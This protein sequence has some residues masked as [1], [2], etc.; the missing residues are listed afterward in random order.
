[1][2]TRGFHEADL[3]AVIDDSADAIISISSGGSILGFNPAAERLFHRDAHSTIGQ[4]VN[5]LMPEPHRSGHDAYMKRYL[6]TGVKR[7]LGIGRRVECIRPDGKCFPAYLSVSEVRTDG[8]IT[9]TGI[10]RDLTEQQAIEDELR[11]T[12]E[13]QLLTVEFAPIGIA[14][15]DRDGNLMSLNKAGARISGYASADVIGSEGLS[16]LHLDDQ[17]HI[18][19]SFAR[20]LRDEADHSISTHRLRAANGCYRTAQFYIAVAHD[21]S[22]RPNVLICMFQDL[23][24]QHALEAELQMQRERL[25]HLS[26]L[27]TMGEMA[28]GLA[29][30]LNQPLAAISTYAQVAHRLLGSSNTNSVE[31]KS[32]CSK[33]ADQAKRASLIVENMRSQT[34]KT[35]T[36]RESV[37][38]NDLVASLKTL[39][40]IDARYDN[41]SVVCEP[42]GIP[43][44]YADRVQIEQ[45]ILNL[46]RNAIDAVRTVK[47][48]AGT[49]RILT[50]TT[51]NGSAELSVVDNGPGVA[52]EDV[53]SLFEVF[54]TTKKSGTGMGLSISKTIIEAHAGEIGY[55]RAAEDGAEFW[56]SLPPENRE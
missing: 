14:T 50:R 23:T 17:E 49:V 6:D 45:V 34:R 48:Q 7:I 13:Q 2:S 40:D 9:F 11:R 51:D 52:A 46:V 15:L 32:V 43:S 53:E 22:G 31:L 30:E 10:L 25:A 33:I 47:D 54:Y 41:V 26:R 27:H 3:R 19:R 4:P 21:S 28:A 37:Q 20:L 35:S 44:V 56:F 18:R 55:R 42:E 5:I 38:L 12:R 24:D 39:I 29:H 36:R 16:F 8:H 1:M